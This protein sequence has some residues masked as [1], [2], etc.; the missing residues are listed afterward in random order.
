MITPMKQII[1]L[2]LITALALPYVAQAQPVGPQGGPPSHAEFMD[3]FDEDGDGQLSQAERQQARATMESE[4][5][6]PGGQRAQIRQRLIEQFDVDG[7]GELTGQER[8]QAA[9]AVRKQMALRHFDADGDGELSEAERA[10]ALRFMEERRAQALERFDA[11]GDG[12][13]SEEERAT[14]R[15]TM[16][17]QGAGKFGPPKGAGPR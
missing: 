10:E 11:N 2:T 17:G 6:R 1:R 12:Q 4:G 9:Q 16:R 5:M 7:D 8:R 3:R 13:I 14:A 15:E